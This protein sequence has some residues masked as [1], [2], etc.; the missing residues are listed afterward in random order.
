MGQ[1]Q[2][3]GPWE[4]GR[5][6]PGLAPISGHGNDPTLLLEVRAMRCR[7]YERWVHLQATLA[8]QILCM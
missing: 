2:T 8:A 3:C 1:A 7:M 6:C 4:L 5:A